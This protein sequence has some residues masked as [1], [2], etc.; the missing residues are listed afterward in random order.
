MCI[1]WT[2]DVVIYLCVLLE[3][4]LLSVNLFREPQGCLLLK[5]HATHVIFRRFGVNIFV[6][7]QKLFRPIEEKSLGT[8]DKINIRRIEY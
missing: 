5:Y 8:T 6:G 4:C 1:I 7:Q 2:Q 3:D